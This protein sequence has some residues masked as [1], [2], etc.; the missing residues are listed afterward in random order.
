MS[1]KENTL[2]REALTEEIRRKAAQAPDD[3]IPAFSEVAKKELFDALGL[4]RYTGEARAYMDLSKS[5]EPITGNPFK[6]F[7]KKFCTR[8][9]CFFMHR[10]GGFNVAV[11][12]A[13]DQLRNYVVWEELQQAK[14]QREAIADLERKLAALEAQNEKLSAQVDALKVGSSYD[15]S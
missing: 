14:A 12:R 6:R 2:D 9:L 5:F 8:I 7:L 11:V 10:Q 15:Q 13:L 1:D 3:E 4:E